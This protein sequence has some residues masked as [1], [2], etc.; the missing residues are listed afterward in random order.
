MARSAKKHENG[1]IT[2]SNAKR[3]IGV[4]KVVGPVL[5]PFALKAISAAR[6]SYDRMRA[7]QLG[8][9]VED[10]GRFTGKGAALHARIAGDLDT[11]RELRSR[12]AGRTDKDSVAAERFA[13]ATGR[14]LGQLTSAVR[15]AEHMPTARRRAAHR[16][17]SGELGRIED[18]LLNR[19]GV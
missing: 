1:R 15:A 8:V 2:P 10:L 19:L 17:V 11:L 5:A 3:L 14:R 7:R 4:A 9:P 13:D 6:E 18:D 12:S 16:A